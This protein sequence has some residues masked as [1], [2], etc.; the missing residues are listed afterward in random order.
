MF[1]DSGRGP[2]LATT[3][4]PSVKTPQVVGSSSSPA[5]NKSQKVYHIL[6]IECLFGFRSSM[7]FFHYFAHLG[8]ESLWCTGFQHYFSAFF[9]MFMFTFCLAFCM[10]FNCFGMDG[11]C[12]FSNC[13]RRLKLFF[14]L[15]SIIY[16]ILRLWRTFDF[17]ISLYCNTNKTPKFTV[18]LELNC[19]SVTNVWSVLNGLKILFLIH[20][21]RFL[22]DK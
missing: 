18:L 19:K 17:P 10:L 5:V 20:K 8:W 9:S 21:T 4:T 12:G 22:S 6:H 2:N 7:M 3:A 15:N 14:L 16:W 1:Q 11:I 13:D